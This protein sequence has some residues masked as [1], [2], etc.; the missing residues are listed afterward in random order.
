MSKFIVRWAINAVALF[1]AIYIVNATIGGINVESNS[2]LAYA[3]MGLVFG[4]VNALFRPLLS[5]LTCPLIILTLGLFTIVVNTILFYLVGW[6]GRLFGVGFTIENFW[7][8]L[9]GSV[10]VSLVS[11]ILTLMFKGELK[12][13][14]HR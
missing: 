11:V 14:K 8:A 9:F 10:L 1:V 4:L 13:N 7:S 2:W 3:W 12:E 6:F 5:I